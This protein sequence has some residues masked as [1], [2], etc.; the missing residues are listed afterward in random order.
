M[1]AARNG[2]K[3]ILEQLIKAGADKDIQ[4]INGGTA[5]MYC[6]KKWS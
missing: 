5:L 6:S 3:E 1:Y 2:H 4:D